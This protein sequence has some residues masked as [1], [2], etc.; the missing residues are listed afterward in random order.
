MAVGTFF[1]ASYGVLAGIRNPVFHDEYSYLLAADTFVRGRITNPPPSHPEFFEAQHILVR[2]SYQSKYLPG[3]G[4]ALAAGARIFGHAIWG[5][6]LTCGVF[7]GSLC[8]MLQAFVPRKWAM[9]MTIITV[10]T[11]GTSTYWAQS[12]WGGMLAATGSALLL[13]GARRLL[14]SPER[15]PAALL[16]L[17]AVVLAVT[18]PY[19]GFLLACAVAIVFLCWFLPN[20]VALRHTLRVAGLPIIVIGVMGVS[21]LALYNKAVTGSVL[22]LPYSLHHRQYFHQ[23]PF[24]FN[25]LRPPERTPPSRIARFYATDTSSPVAGIDAV[26]KVAAN[27]ALRGPQTLLVPFGFVIP[28]GRAE[29]EAFRGISLWLVLLLIVSRAWSRRAI[30]LISATA[31]GAELAL[32][33]LP[34]YPW[35]LAPLVV[36]PWLMAIKG[37]L[38][39]RTVHWPGIVAVLVLLLGQSIIWWWSPHYSA[40]LVPLVLSGIVIVSRRIHLLASARRGFSTALATAMALHACALLGSI[41]LVRHRLPE[42]ERMDRSAVERH[43]TRQDGSHVVFVQYSDDYTP[44]LE[45]VYNPADLEGASVIFAH[46]LGAAKNRQLLA[47]CSRRHAWRLRI[48][49]ESVEL[50]PYQ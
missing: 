20:R 14:K 27:V 34:G 31:F 46:D 9:A 39:N 24:I 22:T 5:V 45:W 36:P 44:D 43:L 4:L 15:L 7:A 18:R 12:Y 6:W 32:W 35:S 8:W 38:R 2:P 17:G 37:V 23:G 16:G 1:P 49:P 40:P 28:P 25:G 29:P 41:A 30:S 10:A 3:Q 33:C 26:V 42:G 11:L 13:G 21:G 48:S 50:R 19:E 47:D